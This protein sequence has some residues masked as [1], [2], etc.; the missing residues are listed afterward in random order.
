MKFKILAKGAIAALMSGVVLASMSITSAFAADNGT[1]ADLKNYVSN[2]NAATDSNFQKQS[3]FTGDTSGYNIYYDGDGVAWLI[4][5]SSESSVN[6]ADVQGVEDKLSEVQGDLGLNA[7]T[8][9]AGKAMSGFGGLISTILGFL[10]IF[11]GGY[12]TVQ[13]AL[14]ICY[15]AFPVFRGKCD[16]IKQKSAG[17]GLAAAATKQGKD[18]E[19]RLRLISDDAVYA[20]NT[21]NTTE[22]GK[23]PFTIYL[24]K[25]IFAFMLVAVVL[26]IFISG[27]VFTF[28]KLAVKLVSGLLDLINGLI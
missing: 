12:L 21:A 7:D 3:T 19:T 4:A 9:T 13:T 18:G 11:I 5:K 2:G 25:R 23:N 16:D 24:G 15:V 20:V 6:A 28:T 8:T 17:G 14:D 10:V 1:D 22:T 27:N 26:Y